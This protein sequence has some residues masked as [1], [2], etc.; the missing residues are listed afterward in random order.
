MRGGEG[1]PQLEAARARGEVDRQLQRR[2]VLS[3]SLVDR[4]GLE[5][6]LRGHT[7]CV[8]CLEWNR[9]GSLVFHLVYVPIM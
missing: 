3:R 9:D 4:L 2:L 5:N 7:G 6:E 8:N 1:T